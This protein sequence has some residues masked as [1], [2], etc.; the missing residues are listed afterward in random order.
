MLKKNRLILPLFGD[1]ESEIKNLLS[2]IKA[3]IDSDESSWHDILRIYEQANNA[4]MRFR[5]YCTILLSP[6]I[7]KVFSQYIKVQPK[8][9][10]VFYFGGKIRG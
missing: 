4:N 7:N 2:K 5:G 8:K 9:Q 10:L 3:L 6:N 1:C